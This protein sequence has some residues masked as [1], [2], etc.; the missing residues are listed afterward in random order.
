MGKL[1]QCS[2]ALTDLQRY[3]EVGTLDYLRDH[4]DIYYAVC[5]RFIGGIEA[6]FDAGQII[7]ASHGQHAAGDG[8]IPVL[9]GRRKIISDELASAFTN[10]Y[11]F[12]NRLVHAYG[13]LDDSKVA[14]YLQR[15]LVDIEELISVF[16]DTVTSSE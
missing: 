6:L 7:L 1:V 5:Y 9:L 12:R 2:E 8:D 11:G 14:E 3:R 10:M 4:Q 13:T 15:H 16:R